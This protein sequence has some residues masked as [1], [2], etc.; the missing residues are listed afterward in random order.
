MVYFRKTTPIPPSF[1]LPPPRP[2]SLIPAQPQ[3]AARNAALFSFT[4]FPAFCRKN[5]IEARAEHLFVE[6]H[7]LFWESLYPSHLRPNIVPTPLSS[8]SRVRISDAIY[9]I[10]FGL[11]GLSSRIKAN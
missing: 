8:C 2:P 4:Y 3:P 6:G 1:L 9:N 5:A 10:E 7:H 11:G